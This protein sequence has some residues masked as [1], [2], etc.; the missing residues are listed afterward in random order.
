MITNIIFWF[1]LLG[2]F[3]YFG[4]LLLVIRGLLGLKP[5]PPR[6]DEF[7]TVVIPFRNEVL[8]I[9]QLLRSLKALNYP[10][11]LFEIIFI[12][13]DSSDGGEKLVEAELERQP[14]WCLISIDEKPEHLRGKKYG[15][16]KAI[17]KSR[18]DVILTTDADCEVPPNWIQTMLGHLSPDV[19]MVLGH[20]PIHEEDSFF[21]RLISFD[22]LSGST[23]AAAGAFYNKPPHANGRNL[24]YRKQAF[25]DVKGYSENGY[26]DSGDDFF[27][28]Q[29]IREKTEWKFNF[30]LDPNAYVFTKV[31]PFGK[32]F[33]F[34]QIRRNS[35]AIH[36]TVP[37]LLVAFG[38]LLHIVG[39]PFFM[40][41]GIIGVQSKLAILFIK[42][43]LEFW[44]VV[45]STK[46]LH[47]LH[48]RKYYPI[49]LVLYPVFIL[50]FSLAGS[51]K[52]YRWK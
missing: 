13:D 16:T 50:L 21:H 23:V 45:V 39:F 32:N 20:S 31:H 5:K 17:E 37:F 51:L 15:L 6:R 42:I 22:V 3:T 24:I 43:S 47:L 7:V 30:C 40:L 9:T 8:N 34:Q 10:K 11:K 46:K 12:N 29:A 33:L 44:T 4:I 52:L 35:K 2:T 28:S 26:I 25:F 36:H 41:S 19:G 14:H 18:G 1:F 49:M 27:L 48:L 38:I